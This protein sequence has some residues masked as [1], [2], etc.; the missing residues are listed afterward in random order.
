MRIRTLTEREMI[1]LRILDD[2]VELAALATFLA[3]IG[4][5][6]SAMGAA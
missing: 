6:A 5:W 4:V 2:V 1:M 3:M